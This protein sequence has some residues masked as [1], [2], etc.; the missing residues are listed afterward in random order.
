MS[1]RLSLIAVALLL[2]TMAPASADDLEIGLATAD[3]TPPVG[4]RMSGYFSERASTGVKDPLKAKAIVYRQGL[5][6]GAMVFCDLIGIDKST[7]D[8]IRAA[9]AEQANIPAS[10]VSVAATHSH[11]GPL[12][13]GVLRDHFHARAIAS[14]GVDAH[15]SIDYAA[16]LVK[17]VTGTVAQAKRGLK[18]SGIASAVGRGPEVSFNR[19]FEMKDG[20]NRFNPG[21]RNPEIRR[22]LGPIDPEVGLL[23]FTPRGESTPAGSLAVFALHLDTVGGTA[24][25][26]DY[27]AV[28]AEKL[29][30]RY[31]PRFLSAFGAGTCGDINHIDVR[32]ATIRKT[33]EIGRLLAEIPLREIPGM[34]P[35]E[36]MLRIES[37][38]VE[39]PALRIDA[40]E[41]ARSL[42][43]L[44]RLGDPKLPFL[45]AVRAVTAIDLNRN[46]KAGVVP[47]EVQAWRLGRET[48][49]VFLPGEVFVEH[50]LAIKK[51]SPFRVTLVVELANSCPHYIPTLKACREGSYEVVNSRIAPGGGEAMVAA[52]VE[53]LTRL[54]P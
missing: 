21:L 48:A 14:K 18:A 47:I 10:N 17:T 13:E 39:V 34:V 7:G 6:E 16:F 53:L 41:V 45:E 33:A 20:T 40:A 5:V 32:A 43:M 3:I 51:A 4:Y 38:V 22:V 12:C 11:T 25:S 36:P 19:R 44:D 52:A 23:A 27:P 2:G 24:Y 50:G 9:V 49:V 29:G 31:G 1:H 42:P 30:E 46:Y 8:A 37:K 28:I 26:A 15:E 54:R 35:F